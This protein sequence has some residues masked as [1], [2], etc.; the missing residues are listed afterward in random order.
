MSLETKLNRIVV[1]FNLFSS[2]C[3]F[4]ANLAYLFGVKEVFMSSNYHTKKIKIIPQNQTSP[5]SV[6]TE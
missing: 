4:Y 5:N 3:W 2:Q 6:Y 1:L